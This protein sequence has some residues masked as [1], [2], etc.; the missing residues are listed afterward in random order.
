MILAAA[1]TSTPRASAR[2]PLAMKPERL[3]DVVFGGGRRPFVAYHRRPSAACHRKLSGEHSGLPQAATSGLPQA[4]I[5]CF[6]GSLLHLARSATHKQH[7]VRHST[8]VSVCTIERDSS[9][10]QQPPRTIEATTVA[11]VAV[12]ATPVAATSV[13]AVAVVVAALLI[14]VVVKVVVVIVI[15]VW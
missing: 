8:P 11:M 9:A 14:V 12:I 13:V 3:C 10:T 15:M 4:A 2:P 6:F 5:S 1:P 7:A